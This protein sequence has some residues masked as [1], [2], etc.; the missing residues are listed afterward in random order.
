MRKLVVARKCK[1]QGD[2]EGLDRHDG[3]GA[4]SRADREVNDG[5]LLAV[6]RS[7]LVN[8]DDGEYD[9]DDGIEQE[10]LSK[11]LEPCQLHQRTEIGNACS[12]G[13]IA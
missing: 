13:W 10:G 3:D 5:V 6:D 12:P 11:Q 2:S 9:D 4:D 1:L 7:N 8:H